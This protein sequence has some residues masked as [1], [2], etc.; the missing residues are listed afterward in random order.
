MFIN[1]CAGKLPKTVIDWTLSRRTALGAQTLGMS[2]LRL[3]EVSSSQL[4]LFSP[5]INEECHV[6]ITKSFAQLR[7]QFSH[8]QI[9]QFKSIVYVCICSA[10]YF[11][12]NLPDCVHAEASKNK[13]SMSLPAE[14]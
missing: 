10:I 13:H 1:R 12:S 6:C 7:P 4:S 8:S 9:Q 3:Q 11:G 14:R 2:S 5:F